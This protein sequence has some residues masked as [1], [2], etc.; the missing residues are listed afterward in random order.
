MKPIEFIVWYNQF[1]STINPLFVIQTFASLV[2]QI[3]VDYEPKLDFAANECKIAL[4]RKL[5]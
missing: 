1:K 4:Y 5:R 2:N 3:P